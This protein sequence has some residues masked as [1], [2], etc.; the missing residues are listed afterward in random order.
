VARHNTGVPQIAIEQVKVVPVEDGKRLG[1]EL[2]FNRAGDA[3][4][5]GTVVV[6]MQRDA[7]SRVEK[8]GEYKEL[9][10]YRELGKR[11]VTIPLREKSIPKGAIVRIA[12]E[13]TKEY[14]GTLWAEKVFK[15][16]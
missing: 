5:F 4:S 8:I 15:T 7:N 6:E 16:E 11:K 10:I 14:K 9:S 3:S 12:Y 13:G 2:T 1:L